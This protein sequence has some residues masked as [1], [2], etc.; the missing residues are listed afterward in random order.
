M[1]L[2]YPLIINDKVKILKRPVNGVY[3]IEYKEYGTENFKTLEWLSYED[4]C[5]ATHPNAIQA[6]KDV[7]KFLGFETI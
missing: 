5:G 7:K 3:M 1:Y 6:I 2:D 4:K